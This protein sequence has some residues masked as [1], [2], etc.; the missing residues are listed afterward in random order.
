MFEV[1]AGD[2]ANLT[3]KFDTLAEQIAR[4]HRAVPEELVKWQRDDMHRKFPNI[5]VAASTQQTSAITQIWPRGRDDRTTKQAPSPR[6]PRTYRPRQPQ[7]R[8]QVASNWPI[9][10]DVLKEKLDERMTQLIKE[11]MQWP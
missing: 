11:G 5:E 2:L 6:G 9:L 10:R 7:P 8:A 1:D 4:L 3:T